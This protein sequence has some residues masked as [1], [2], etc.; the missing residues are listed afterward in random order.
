[1]TRRVLVVSD[2][3]PTSSKAD[4]LFDTGGCTLSSG[5]LTCALG[6]MT[7]GSVKSFN[8]HVRVKGSA[9]QISNTA[10]VSSSTFDPDVSNN[11]ST[12]VVLV[13]GGT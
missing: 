13:K 6:N 11:S 9:G 8:V 2:V 1:M 7:A 4:Y 10:S 12:R 3:L 5:V